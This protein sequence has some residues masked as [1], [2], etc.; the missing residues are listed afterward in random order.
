MLAVHR[1]TTLSS[2]LALLNSRMWARM[3]STWTQG[4]GVGLRCGGDE[5]GIPH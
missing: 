2:V 5:E 1:M 4:L 3:A